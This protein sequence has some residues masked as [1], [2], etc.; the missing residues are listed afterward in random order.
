MQISPPGPES[1]V[2][3]PAE[4]NQEVRLHLEAGFPRLWIEAELSNL[5]RPASGHLCFTLK[6]ARAQIRCALF[7]GNALQMGF[8]PE[9]GQKVLVRGRLSLYEARG[10]YQLIADAML[11]AGAGSLQAAFEALKKTLQAEGLFDADRKQAIPAWPARIAVVTSPSGAAIQDILKVLS[12]RWPVAEVRIYPTRVQ[13]ETAAAEIVRTLKAADRHADCDVIV[14]ARGGGSLEDLWAFNDEA[15]ARAI[16]DCR[17]PVVSGVGHETDV[18]IADYAAD[19]RAPT[20]SAAAAA[21]TPDGPALGL[22]LRTLERQHRRA[23]ENG[24]N[25]REQALDFLTRRL[26]QQH[27]ER[28]LGDIQDRLA[29]L[30]RRLSRALSRQM[31]E[32]HQRLR[33]LTQRLRSQRPER[34]L[35]HAAGSVHQLQQR[36]DR[37]F[38][39]VVDRSDQRLAT[40]LRALNAVSPLAVLERGYAVIRD[41]EGHPIT[42]IE[43]FIKNNRI[44]ILMDEFEVDAEVKSDPRPARLS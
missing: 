30:D 34:R 43:G 37:A 36:L 38:G 1:R 18:T 21:V 39:L 6:D 26:E 40:L 10:D 41:A 9:N 29:G 8:R 44:N 24:L 31:D 5:A 27:P 2:Y 28:R 42:G 14:L 33:T 32:H 16:V 4:L 19:L 11:E 7:R 23:L 25:R 15:L 13:G 3:R 12:Q 20:P 17:T 35:E 22:R